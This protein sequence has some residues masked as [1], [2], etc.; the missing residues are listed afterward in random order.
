MEQLEFETTV[1]VARLCPELVGYHFGECLA[2]SP[3]HET[4]QII[5]PAGPARLLQ[6]I[7]CVDEGQIRPACERLKTITHPRLLPVEYY[8]AESGQLLVLS[9]GPWLSL[10][11]RFKECRDQGMQG[12][13]RLELISYLKMVAEALDELHGSQGLMHLTLNPRNL[14]MRDGQPQ[15]ADFGL[16][17]LCWLPVRQ[18]LFPLNPRYS[19]P[20]IFHGKVTRRADQCSLALIYAEM[21]TG[22]HPAP[23]LGMPRTNRRFELDLRLL[24]SHEQKILSRAMSLKAPD[25]Y[26]S[27]VDLLHDLETQALRSHGLDQPKVTVL[28]PVIHAPRPLRH[29]EP[30]PEGLLPSHF[31]SRLLEFT[32]GHSHSKQFEDF[33]YTL[34]PGQ[35]L[36]HRF[37]ISL[38]LEAAMACLELSCP[39]WHVRGQRLSESTFTIQA[40]APSGVWR[41]LTARRRG[42]EATLEMKPVTLARQTTMVHARLQVLPLGCTGAE[43]DGM[44]EQIGLP[45][46]MQLRQLLRAIPEMR[47]SERLLFR[48]PLQVTPVGPDLELELPIHCISKDISVGGVG[49]FSREEVPTHDVYINLPWLPGCDAV[50]VRA[51]IVRGRRTDNGWYELG[52]S[53][54]VEG[55]PGVAG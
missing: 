35:A 3:V 39:Q 20:E 13:P 15:I 37:L 21:L 25:R 8:V 41:L 51:R 23:H 6:R 29:E 30:P 49:F 43:A 32:N 9:D 19:A 14:L 24:S 46:L 36:E 12:I 7:R 27:C 22:A 42:V 38:G 31:L 52:A 18:P 33:R 5:P 17:Q 2:R 4:W 53:F 26:S 34:Q 55:P 48:Q 54:Q 16:A 50:A 44:L 40:L 28:P 11:D 10:F 47:S 1:P 45:L